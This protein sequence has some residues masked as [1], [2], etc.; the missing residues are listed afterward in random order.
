MIAVSNEAR[1]TDFGLAKKLGDPGHTATGAVMGTPSY[2][3]PEQAGGMGKEVGP[4][5][6]IYALGAILNELLTGRP[7]FKAATPLDSHDFNPIEQMWSKIKGYLRKVK[8]RDVDALIAA[9]GDALKTITA[10][11]AMGWF[12]HCG[13]Q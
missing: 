1:I 12:R 10:A 6:D 4:A 7:P 9:I 3:A 11:D 5:A 8:P 13:Y 2:M